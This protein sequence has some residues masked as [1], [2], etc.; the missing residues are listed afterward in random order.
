MI[1]TTAVTGPASGLERV[2]RAMALGG[3]AVFVLGLYLDA[4]AS[5]AGVLM[6][7]LALLGFAVAGPFFAAI[8]EL[9]SARWAIPFRPV[10][11]A[12]GRTL[13]VAAAFGVLIIFGTSALYSW[14]HAG[15]DGAHATSHRAGWLN[16]PFF[17]A[18]LLLVLA[19]WLWL[20][21]RLGAS[22]R[23]AS[24]AP[25][26]GSRYRALRDS[27]VFLLVFAVTFSVASIDWFQSIEPAWFSTMYALLIMSGIALSGVALVM[28]MSVLSRRAGSHRGI[29]TDGFDDLGKVALSLTLFW[30]YIRFCQYMLVWYTNMPEETA[31]YTARSGGGW[32]AVELVNVALNWLVPFA[33][34]MPRTLRRNEDMILR[35]GWVLLAGRIVDIVLILAP[36]L[37]PTF[38]LPSLLALAP[39]TGALGLFAWRFLAAFRAEASAR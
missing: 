38:T 7:F 18:R 25:S 24:S 12:M 39:L 36:P 22:L 11:D 33:T 4:R 20:A 6:G 9:T 15:G 13:P 16:T 37:L 29:T 26:S 30:G 8:R 28:V 2:F 3:A 5:W 17:A 19:M 1:R 32:P 14:A 10:I 31:W 35:V 34:L 27:A 21:S 23:H